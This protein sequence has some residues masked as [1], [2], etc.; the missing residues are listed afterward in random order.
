MLNADD[1]HKMEAATK[2]ACPKILGIPQCP[3]QAFSTF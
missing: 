3:I 2:A 1:R